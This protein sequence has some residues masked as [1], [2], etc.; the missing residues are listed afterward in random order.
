[1]RQ[2]DYSRQQC[3]REIWIS[4][5]CSFANPFLNILGAIHLRSRLQVVSTR[6]PSLPPPLCRVLPRLKVTSSWILLPHP[7]TNADGP[8]SC[9]KKLAGRPGGGR[10]RLLSEFRIQFQAPSTPPRRWTKEQV[11]GLLWA[12]ASGARDPRATTQTIRG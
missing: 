8:D 11:S 1:M 6:P 2:K 4:K 10:S 12:A 3:G 9:L 7:N 5:Q